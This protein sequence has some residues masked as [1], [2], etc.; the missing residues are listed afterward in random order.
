[1]I[2]MTQTARLKIAAAL[3]IA[4]GL[5]AT[6][7]TLSN[8]DD[9]DDELV[10]KV[11]PSDYEI[12]PG[13]VFPGGELSSDTIVLQGEDYEA[14]PVTAPLLSLHG[15]DTFI[16]WGTGDQVVVD[17]LSM[18]SSVIALTFFEDAGKAIVVENYSGAL[19]AVPLSVTFNAPIL[20]QDQGDTTNEALWRLG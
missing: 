4:V 19:L 9:D 10:K 13:S 15:I 14:F 11:S 7:I 12:A 16:D 8:L 17:D 2:A 18:Y 1:M 20:Y 5:I 6:T 3:L